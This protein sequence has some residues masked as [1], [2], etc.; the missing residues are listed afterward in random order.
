MASRIRTEKASL[1]SFSSRHPRLTFSSIKPPQSEGMNPEGAAAERLRFVVDSATLFFFFFFFTHKERRPSPLYKYTETFLSQLPSHK[2]FAQV[3]N[4]RQRNRFFAACV[5]LFASFCTHAWLRAAV[6][7]K[8]KR[9]KS[10]NGVWPL[11]ATSSP[12]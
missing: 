5:F 3:E 6:S 4:V 10:N 1:R 11:R 8:V 9:A 12:K 2:A 7:F